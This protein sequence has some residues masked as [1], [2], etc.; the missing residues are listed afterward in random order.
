[1]CV[2]KNAVPLVELKDSFRA[3]KLKISSD[4]R[5]KIKREREKSDGEFY[6]HFTRTK[7]RFTI[8]KWHTRNPGRNETIRT[9]NI[10]TREDRR[11]ARGLARVESEIR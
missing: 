10:Y 4:E 1:M 11:D 7:L 5:G 6:L 3:K 8:E 9:L 2:I